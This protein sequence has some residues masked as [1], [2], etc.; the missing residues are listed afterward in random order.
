ME[1]E[2][3]SLLGRLPEVEAELGGD[4]PKFADFLSNVGLELYNE[5]R[6]DEAEPL[7]ARALAIRQMALAVDH[8]DVGVALN[9]LARIYLAQGR[10]A[11][12]E[13]LFSK[14]LPIQERASGPDNLGVAAGL[15]NLAELM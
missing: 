15:N 10:Y 6:F 9:N 2:I 1:L 4:T 13:P 5:S 3:E 7:L 11:E 14:A 8:A 12:A